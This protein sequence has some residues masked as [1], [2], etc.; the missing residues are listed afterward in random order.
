M[1]PPVRYEPNNLDALHA[2]MEFFAIFWEPGWIEYFQ[3]LNGFHEQ[4]SFQFSMN[5][6]GDHYE[7]R[8]LRIDVSKKALAEVTGLPRIEN[9]W[10]C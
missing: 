7:I 5:L 6:T 3:R 9:G 8:G 2:N 10:F 4:T 1:G